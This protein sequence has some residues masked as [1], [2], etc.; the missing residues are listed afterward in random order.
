METIRANAVKILTD[1]M[2]HVNAQINV[3]AGPGDGSQNQLFTLKSYVENEAK[4][5]PNFFRWLFNN[6]DIDFH[7][8]NMTP[9]QKEEYEAWFNEL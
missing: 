9:E 3:Q 8:K 1:N 4:N 7:G 5:N 2:N 6:Y